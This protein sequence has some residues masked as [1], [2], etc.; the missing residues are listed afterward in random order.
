V[1]PTPI[2]TPT[3]MPSGGITML[4]N[5]TGR[6]GLT[7]IF[8]WNGSPASAP[9]TGAQI[10]SEAPHEDSV[11]GAFFPGTWTGAH[12]GIILSFYTVPVE[13]NNMASGHDLSWWQT[14]HPDWILYAC[15]SDGTPTKDLAWSRSGF[16]DVPLDF[17]NPAV[18]AYQMSVLIPYLKAKGYTALAAD[19]TDLLNYTVGGN[20]EF[21]Q[22]VKA[23]EYGCGTYDTSGNF[24]RS[25]DGP[26]NSPNDTAF[27][28]AMVNWVRTVSADLHAAGLRLMINHPLYNPPTNANEQQM[29]AVI[30][31]MVDENGYTHYGTLLNTTDFAFT[32]SWVEYLQ[33]HRVAT[34]LVDYFCTGSSCSNNVESLT[35]QQVDWALASY[36]IG[37]EGGEDL[38]TSPAG[39]Q[40]Y[41]YRPEY[42]T[43]YGAPCGSYTQISSYV[44]ERKFQGALVIVNATTG[45]YAFSLPANHSYR[46]I[47]GQAVTNPLT[48]GPTTGYV[49]LTSN[50]CS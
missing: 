23:G 50:G 49:L 21:G 13:D 10:D 37:N 36:A 42:S 40:V 44:Y 17:S 47:E 7:Q 3:P 8:D 28:A 2:V 35:P 4:P 38:Y 25:F 41:S 5:T 30:D 20:E 45:N 9:M 16:Q 6:F 18:I 33:T 19:N 11:W 14:N 43:T 48:L 22:T 32:L 27:V 1:T 31:G 39:G 24:H 34:L 46:D 26:L 12:P 29:I 15:Q